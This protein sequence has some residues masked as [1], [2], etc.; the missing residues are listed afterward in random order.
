[1]IDL[2]YSPEVG[3]EFEDAMDHTGVTITS[4]DVWANEVGFTRRRK[5]ET[6]FN[7]EVVPIEDFKT[8]VDTGIF[9]QIGAKR[10]D[11]KNC[12]HEWDTY[13]GFSWTFKFCK[14][15]G[16]QKHD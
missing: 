12:W 9:R 13:V 6:S 7:F 16:I 1:M 4:I 8:A 14:A 15:C 3:D 5:G 2:G 11:E 10:K